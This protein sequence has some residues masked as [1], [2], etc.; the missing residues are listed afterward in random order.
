MKLLQNSHV[1]GIGRVADGN[2]LHGYIIPESFVKVVITNI[3]SNVIPHLTNTI[4]QSHLS[5]GE[6][7]AWPTSQCIML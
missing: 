6:F 3:N 2:V 1:I 7:T 4:N 5:V